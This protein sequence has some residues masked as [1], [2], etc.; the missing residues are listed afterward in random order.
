MMKM[1]LP[2]K[3]YS[4]ANSNDHWCKKSARHKKQKEAIFY[5]LRE[6]IYEKMLPCKIKLT[7]IAPRKLDVHD[8]LPFSFK[9]IFDSI[10]ELLI[11]GKAVGRADDDNRIQVEYDQRKGD[12]NEYAM[13]IEIIKL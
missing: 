10:C 7:R 9:W 6:H 13:E 3:V 2:I 4:E 11:P 1:K 8:N 5:E 12:L